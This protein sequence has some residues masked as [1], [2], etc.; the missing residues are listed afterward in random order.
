MSSYSK[1]VKRN[2]VKLYKSKDDV[3][4]CVDVRTADGSV[5]KRSVQMLHLLEVYGSD[6]FTPD[7]ELEGD[8]S[9]PDP[10]D[11]NRSH[12]QSHSDPNDHD[13]SPVPSDN[14]SC[15]HVRDDDLDTLDSV[16]KS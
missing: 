8:P 5:Y 9:D 3:I 14:D 1:T 7:P 4:R 2:A 10:N 13:S 6:D 12:V 11:H 16:P 15:S